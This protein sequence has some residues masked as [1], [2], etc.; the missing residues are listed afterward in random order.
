MNSSEEN[1]FKAP[2]ASPVNPPTPQ[3]SPAKVRA[4]GKAQ[5]LV[6]YGIL[7]YLLLIAINVG[8]G[9]VAVDPNE[10][11]ALLMLL[12]ILSLVILIFVVFAVGR[13]A[14][15]LHGIGNAIIYCC[16]LY[17]SPSPRDATLSRMPSS[18]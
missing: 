9:S 6:N 4:V 5:R 2:L 16:L 18:A 14:Y 12:P 13:L 15:A 7:L 3:D 10:P 17:T 11:S 8:L 1:P